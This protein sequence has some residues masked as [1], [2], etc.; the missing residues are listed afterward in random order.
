MMMT[1][2]ADDDK[3]MWRIKKMPAQMNQKVM[4]VRG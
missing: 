1:K 2:Q 4:K 3:L